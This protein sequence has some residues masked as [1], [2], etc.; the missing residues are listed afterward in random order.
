M[1]KFKVG[2]TYATRS[3]CDWDCIFECTIVKTS[4]SS[5]WFTGSCTSGSK[6]RA[7][8]DWGDESYFMPLGSYSMAPMIK[9]NDLVKKLSHHAIEYKG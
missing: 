7:V 2:E 3:N 4:K 8:K 6:R 9:S 1:N 5:V